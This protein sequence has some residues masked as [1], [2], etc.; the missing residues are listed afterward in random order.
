MI[1]TQFHFTP[2]F[3]I[4]GVTA[5]FSALTTLVA[6]KRR[7]APASQP[8][9]GLMV[10]ITGYAAVAA[11]E[12][13]A[14]ALP[15]KIFWSKMEYVGTGSIIVFFLIFTL[16][17]THPKVHLKTSVGSW[18]WVIPIFNMLLAATNEWHHLVWI[19]FLPGAPGSNMIIYQHGPGYYWTTAWIYIYVLGGCLLL[20]KAIFRSSK[21]HRRQ[22]GLILLGAVIPMIGGSLYVL[23]ITPPSINITP[24]SF[25]LTGLV[26]LASLR[27]QR[28]FDLI[29]IARDQLVESMDDGV[30][31]LDM[32]NRVIDLNPAAEQLVSKTVPWVGQPVDQ[33]LQKWP[34][35]CKF[36]SDR[37]ETK[38]E[39]LVELNQVRWIKVR[40]SPLCD[41]RGHLTGRLIVLHDMTQHY[42]VEM[43]LRQANV[44]LH[45]QLLAI[46]KLQDQLREQAIRDGLTN[47]FNRRYFEETLPRELAQAGRNNQAVAVLLLDIDYFK[48][49]NDTY[50]HQA[51][52]RVLQAFANLLC[53]YG[54]GGG[55]P[56]RYGGEEFALA[57]P[58][59]G[60]EMAYQRAEQIRRSFQ[61]LRVICDCLEIQATVSIGIALF[62]EDGTTS[63][64]LLNKA[65]QALYAAKAAGR[66]CIK[67][68][69]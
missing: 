47:L 5:L 17:F 43:E 14:I 44:R 39:I 27:F 41:L 29:P 38:A 2:H 26:F 21:L 30:L 31:V 15:A 63:D 51:G 42:Q 53:Q 24:M 32:H 18:L 48:R 54:Q 28:T 20:I 66:N 40:I 58:E 55:I 59:M 56:C 3:A 8:F 4:P 68:S 13:A 9:V 45:Q 1:L 65:D 49:I 33:I 6:W 69:Q 34:E 52:D 46:E 7:I 12:A 37:Q 19:N 61:D 22:A 23:R 35:L 11:L 64:D 60:T 16:R 62:P 67:V 36:C 57:L 10:A 25:L 50:G